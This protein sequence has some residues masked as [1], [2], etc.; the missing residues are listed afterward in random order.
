MCQRRSFS[1][2]RQPRGCSGAENPQG[3]VCH[4]LDGVV[5]DKTADGPRAIVVRP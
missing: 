4:A 5:G 2:A 1:R 3:Q